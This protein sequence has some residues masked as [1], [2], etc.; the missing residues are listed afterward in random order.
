VE[1][2]SPNGV[3][4]RDRYDRWF[5][6][7]A[8]FSPSTLDASLAA[9]GGAGG[10]TIADPFCGAATVGTATVSG[11]GNFRGLEAHP[12]ILDLARLKLTSSKKDSTGLSLAAQRVAEAP[13]LPTDGE[14]ELVKRCFNEDTL[15]ALCGMR[16]AIE[17]ETEWQQH[18]T[19]ALLA[20]LRDVAS[21]KVGWPYQRPGQA[22]TPVAKDPR[23][24]FQRRADAIADD[25][26]KSPLA[27]SG[28]VRLGDSRLAQPW[29]DL[30]GSQLADACVSS[31]PYLNNFDYADA[32]RLEVYFLH[33]AT[34]WKELC[35]RIRSRMLIATTQQTRVGRASRDLKSF[36]RTCPS[37]EVRT[38]KLL[39]ELERE[40]TRRPRGKEYDRLVPSYLYGIARV[41]AHLRRHVRTGAMC[42][43]VIGD[44]APYGVYIDTPQL[45]GEIAEHS[46][47]SVEGSRVLRQRGSRWRQNGNRH[48][49]RLDERLVTFKAK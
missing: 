6:Y 10:Q 47:F 29:A 19:W 1:T 45:I 14:T 18:L 7:P 36:K 22:R 26:S 2:G 12:L 44:S 33:Q 4:R 46:G 15:K 28:R 11:N 39:S 48:E 20:T 37:L 21:S 41:L 25:L 34:S 40:R 35:D 38:T 27:N 32:T 49:V 17:N 13:T 8:G 5:R 43:W 16:H 24:R 23:R 3:S 9:V 42:A 31:P 30:F